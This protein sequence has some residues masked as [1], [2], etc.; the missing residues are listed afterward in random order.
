MI[1]RKTLLLASTLFACATR[2]FAVEP[3]FTPWNSDLAIRGYDTVAYFTQNSAVE[4]LSDFEYQWQGATWRFSNEDHLKLF[5]ENPEK[6]APQYGGYCAYAV[7]KNST[8]SIDPS[9]FS[10][11]D[12][13]LYL[14]YNAKIQQRWQEDIAGFIDQADKNWPGLLKK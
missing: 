13:K 14:N 10:I 1:I 9:Q 11:I 12:G 8:A 5:A 6:Y 3:I 4:G 2:V 7:A